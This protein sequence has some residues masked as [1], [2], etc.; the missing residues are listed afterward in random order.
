MARRNRRNDGAINETCGRRRSSRRF[1]HRAGGVALLDGAQRRMTG[2]CVAT[3]SACA[4][5]LRVRRPAALMDGVDT[6]PPPTSQVLTPLCSF[7]HFLF[8]ASV[9][10]SSSIEGQSKPD[11]LRLFRT[12]ITL[13][14][15]CFAFRLIDRIGRAVIAFPLNCNC[16]QPPVR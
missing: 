4:C 9:L 7:S 13:G 15:P 16:A 5:R 12:P 2:R 11:R 6:G 8:V 1:I 14:S 10:V 3:P